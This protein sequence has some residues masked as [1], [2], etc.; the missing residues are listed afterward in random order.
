MKKTFK[1]II[2][3]I[4][5]IAAIAWACSFKFSGLAWFPGFC[6]AT[7]CG[8]KIYELNSIGQNNQKQTRP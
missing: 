2:L 3:A 7:F 1:T 4:V 8:I 5:A 6:V